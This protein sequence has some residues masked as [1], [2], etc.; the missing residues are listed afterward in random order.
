MFDFT[1][2]IYQALGLYKIILLASV[3]MFWLLRA[4][5]VDGKNDAVRGISNFL[6]RVTEPVLAPVRRALPDLG[7]FDVSPIVVLIGIQ[8]LQNLLVK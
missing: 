1:N 4:N 7:G 3:I 8:I 2:I 5:M 6:T